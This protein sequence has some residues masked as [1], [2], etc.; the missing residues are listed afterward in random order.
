[1]HLRSRLVGFWGRCGC[2][3]GNLAFGFPVRRLR[4]GDILVVA[5]GIGFVA[6]WGL[7]LSLALDNAF[8]VG[9]GMVKLLWLDLWYFQCGF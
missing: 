8:V 5:V 4:I 6:C 2:L 1:M 7:M 9:V 3:L